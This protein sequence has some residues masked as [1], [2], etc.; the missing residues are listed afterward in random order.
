[1]MKK[2]RLLIL[3]IVLTAGLIFIG[4]IIPVETEPSDSTRVILEHHQR[5]YIAPV[6]FEDANASNFIEDSTLGQAHK[7][8]YEADSTCTEDALTSEKNP[9]IIGLLKDIG[10]LSTEWDSW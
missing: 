2:K 1:M 3:L 10:I 6:C 7:I 9:L 8:E 4:F 5:T